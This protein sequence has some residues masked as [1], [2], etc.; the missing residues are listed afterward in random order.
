MTLSVHRISR[1]LLA[2]GLVAALA[3]CRVVDSPTPGDDTKQPQAPV[4][5]SQDAQA[6]NSSFPVRRPPAA[7]RLADDTES[8]A[9]QPEDLW[10]RIAAGF[11]LQHEYDNPAVD[12]ELTWYLQN[13]DYIARVTE[14]ATPFLY[15]LV[16]EVEARHMPLELALV[17]I[18]ESGFDPNARSSQRASGLWQFMPQTARGYGLFSD[19]WYDGRRDPIASTRAALDYLQ[20][21]HARFEG[22]WMLALAAYNAGEGNVTR[23]IAR[24]RRNELPTEFWDLRLPAETRSHV[25]RIIAVAKLVAEADAR[26]V[27]LAEIANIPQIETVQ[28]DFQLDLALAAQAANIDLGQLKDLNPGLTQWATHPDRTIDLVLPSTAA[29]SFRENIGRI[30]VDQRVTWDVYRIRPGDTLLAIA[31]RFNT[32]VDQLQRINSLS[33]SRIIAGNSLMIPRSGSMAYAVLPPNP[34]TRNGA[35]VDPTPGRYSVQSGDSLWLIARRFGLQIQDIVA[36][37]GI[38]RNSI[39]RPGQLLWL[40]SPEYV[41]A[42]TVDRAAAGIPKAYKVVRGDSLA[43][44]AARFGVSVAQLTRWNSLD[45]DALIFPGQQLVILPAESDLN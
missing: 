35:D 36:W 24:N 23:A 11:A 39:L 15:W 3:A 10:E 5:A 34:A 4:T 13:Q 38:S 28:L 33:D 6:A 19:W 40:E 8:R 43:R 37:N 18:V 27:Q 32:S 45:R 9:I 42:A 41:A 25:P 22:D 12:T 44:I 16:E 2:G 14:R 7:A 17:P 21:L 31:G 29:A 20:A 30:P 26:G 1:L